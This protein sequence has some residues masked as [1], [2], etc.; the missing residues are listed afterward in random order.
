MK[1]AVSVQHAGSER[2]PPSASPTPKPKEK[3]KKKSNFEH[4]AGCASQSFSKLLAE[5]NA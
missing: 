3:Q 1:L 2:A 4:F 5:K